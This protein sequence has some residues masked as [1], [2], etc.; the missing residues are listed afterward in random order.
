MTGYT[1]DFDGNLTIEPFAPS[2]NNYTYDGENHLVT[3]ASGSTSATYTFDGNGLRV[4]KLSGSTTT[5]Y[6]VTG[7][8]VIAEYVNGS[9][10]KEYVYSGSQLLAT[11]AS[12]ATTYHHADHLS[13][14]IST[15]SSGTKIGDQ[16]H[17]PFGETWY[18]TNT[19][20]KWQFT[21]YE[22]DSESGNDYAMARYYVNRVGRFSSPDP[23]GGFTGSPQT[24]NRYAYVTNIPTNLA[25]PLGLEACLDDE[26]PSE[27]CI[28]SQRFFI[29]K[30]LCSSGDCDGGGGTENPGGG[31]GEIGSPPTPPPARPCSPFNL[32][33][34]NR[35][36]N[37]GQTIRQH[38]ESQH[39]ATLVN[40]GPNP[41][42][43]DP[44]TGRPNS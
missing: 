43:I 1:Y 22:R 25:D 37:D 5:V 12:G 10:S 13:V 3:F 9:L 8:K 24:W 34:Y 4:K 40:G 38:I 18:L 14:R 29:E 36:G 15:N 30:I 11:I 20:T 23:L 31:G 21:S 35:V 44:T 39:M 41:Q 6:V 42:V 19:T 27:E 17:F 2:N 28:I 26:D 32:Q 33:D 16:G 7:G